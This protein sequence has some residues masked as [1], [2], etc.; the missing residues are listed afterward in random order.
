LNNSGLTGTAAT[1]FLSSQNGSLTTRPRAFVNWVLLDENFNI[2]K[3]SA[4]NY[5]RD[6]YSN[7]QQVGDADVFTTH[8]L[9]N[10]PINKNGYLYIYV[11]NQSPNMDVYFDN[12]QV[13]H[14]KGPILEENHYSPWGMTLAAL[15]S[16]ALSGVAENKYKFNGKELN[17]KEFSDGSGLETYDFEA[18][19]YDQQLG[20]FMNPDPH[21]DSYNE[22]SP[23]NFVNNNPLIYIDP[24]GKDFAI[25]FEQDK[26]GNWNVRIT[27]TYY[28]KKGD[29]D[30][31]ESAENAT[32]LWNSESGR[33]VLREGDKK[34]HTDYTINF[35]L[36]VIEVDDPQAEKNKDTKGEDDAK[37]K[38]GSSNLYSVVG[39]YD[40]NVPGLTTGLNKIRVKKENKD[41]V[42]TGP[43]EVGHTF[44]LND[45]GNALMNGGNT[46]QTT[47]YSSDIQDIINF[48]LRNQTNRRITVSGN[49]PKGK[50]KSNPKKDN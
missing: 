15:S 16:K 12:L 30:S 19:M 35:D 20:R 6:G 11:S 32:K 34:N 9:V 28:V 44:G 50:V 5:I 4:G 3:D 31:K 8:S 40:I 10:A 25:Y 17:S 26:D 1:S 43:H 39:N 13:T 49:L 24:T 38:D 18:R 14:I 7:F 41:D 47:I 48:A 46:G 37:T 29:K 33:F 23:Y 22:L 21:S 27:A 42:Q 36:K 45:Q 2:A